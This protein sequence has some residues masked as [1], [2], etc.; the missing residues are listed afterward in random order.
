MAEQQ[1]VAEQV[2]GEY[3]YLHL[4]HLLRFYWVPLLFL[5]WL[6]EGPED[7]GADEILFEG[8]VLGKKMN[9]QS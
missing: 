8:K 1:V 9:Y 7:T 2:D 3:E 6:V 4:H 5:V